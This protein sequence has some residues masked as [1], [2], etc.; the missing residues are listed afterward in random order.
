MELVKESEM[1]CFLCC[2]GL[3]ETEWMIRNHLV[4]TNALVHQVGMPILVFSLDEQ[5]QADL[6]HHAAQRWVDSSI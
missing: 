2:L 1:S 3:L 4:R 6:L 5:F